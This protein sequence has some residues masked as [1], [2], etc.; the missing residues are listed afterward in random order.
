M[1]CRV[2][3]VITVITVMATSS[4]VKCSICS[5]LS[6]NLPLHVS[7]LCM[8]HGKDKEFHMLCG[9][10]GCRTDF[11]SFAAFNSHV[12]RNHRQ[13]MGLDKNEVPETS[14]VTTDDER[15]S[16][17]DVECNISL[18]AGEDFHGEGGYSCGVSME[19]DN[20]R[21]SAELGAGEDF[22]GESRYRFSM[23]D[24]NRRYS[25]EFLLKLME[26]RKLTNVAI[27]VV[28]DG[29][30]T[31]C[32]RTPEQVT[33]KIKDVLLN[34]AGI[35]LAIINEELDTL[36]GSIPDPFAGLETTY[37]QEKYFREHFTYIVS[38]CLSIWSCVQVYR[39]RL[40]QYL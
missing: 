35:D 33:I 13:A 11:H 5:Y 24:D 37:L 40:Q 30:R 25:A 14:V 39:T 28:I 26:G 22:H 6:P 2:F 23:E 20:R 15:P 7:H 10:D 9:I 17:V 29:C 32:S 36:S 27:G 1:R 31:L 18:G 19:G 16:V 21:Y 12:Y 34:S 8:V 3:T 4:V 38:L